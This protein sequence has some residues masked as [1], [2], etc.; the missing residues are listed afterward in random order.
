MSKTPERQIRQGTEPYSGKLKAQNQ[1]NLGMR[2]TGHRHIMPLNPKVL[3]SDEEARIHATAA[4]IQDR[5]QLS[6][7]NDTVGTV[8]ARNRVEPRKAED[9]EPRQPREEIDRPT[10]TLWHSTQRVL[11]QDEEARPH[12][13]TAFIQARC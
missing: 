4:I 1:D 5:W 11:A 8:Q 3:A 13:T 12:A 10:G 7:V 2:Q 6:G 9:S